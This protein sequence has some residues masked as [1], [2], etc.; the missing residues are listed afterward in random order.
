MANQVVT[1]KYQIATYKGTI[2]IMCD[3]NDDNDFIFARARRLLTQQSGGSLPYGMQ[4]FAVIKR[5]YQ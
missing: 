3:E 1:V 2:D 5:E 4:S